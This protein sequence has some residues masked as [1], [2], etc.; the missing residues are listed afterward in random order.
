VPFCCCCCFDGS[1]PG[2]DPNKLAPYDG[3]PVPK[4][5]R[6]VGV[7]P[8]GPDCEPMKEGV[9]PSPPDTPPP[10]L[11]GSANI[12]ALNGFA[13]PASPVAC[14]RR[15]EPSPDPPLNAPN[16]PVGCEFSAPAPVDCAPSPLPLAGGG[17]GDS[18]GDC[19]MGGRDSSNAAPKEEDGLKGLMP[20]NP[21]VCG[22]SGPEGIDTLIDGAPDALDVLENVVA[23]VG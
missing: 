23:P 18:L 8:S 19:G 1:V 10:L 15:P 21:V 20:A 2:P 6:P 14:G 4:D 12:V 13:P 5:G 11:E 16:A 17:F 7:L 9:L 22:I 3:A